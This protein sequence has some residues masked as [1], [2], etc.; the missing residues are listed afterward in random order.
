MPLHSE[1]L[2]RSHPF[3][4]YYNLTCGREQHYTWVSYHFYNIERAV[5]VCDRDND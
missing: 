3:R 4:N 2:E 5:T 1:P